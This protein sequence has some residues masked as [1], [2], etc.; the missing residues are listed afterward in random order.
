MKKKRRREK[1]MPMRIPQN[2]SEQKG[3][4]CRP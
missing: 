1:K 2:K 3:A 4:P